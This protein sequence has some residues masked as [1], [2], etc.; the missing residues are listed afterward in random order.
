[1]WTLKGASNALKDVSSLFI[2]NFAPSS[3][4]RNPEIE[5]AVIKATNHNNSRVDY[6]SAQLL[7][8]WIRVSGHYIRPVMSALTTRMEKTR[9]WTV[10]LKGLMLLHGVFTCKVPAVQKI[11]RL[12][13]DL[14]NF[15]DRKSNMFQH[16]AF[17]RS[18]YT[19]LNK[20]SAFMMKHSDDRK[21]GT[22]R[23]G[24][25]ERPKQWTMMQHLAWLENLQGLLDMLLEI[26]PQ[27]EKMKNVLVLEAMNCIMLEIYD[28]YSRICNGIAAVLVR[29][30]SIGKTEAGMAFSI[31]QKAS[32]QA[33]VL[34][35][36]IDFCR[37]FGVTK[38]SESPKIVHIRKD[39]IQQLEQIINRASSP[40][41]AEQSIP[42][43]EDKPTMPVED[44]VVIKKP[45]T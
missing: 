26:K 18:Y 44:S 23:R 40:Q 11:G 28:I 31:L 2:A 21:E 3:A 20:K 1:M 17:I 29:L 36:Y 41:K 19:Y 25:K 42:N 22:L 33:E 30:Y 43:E 9:S 10:A 7:F 38:A 27:G 16:E 32:T 15:K 14:S 13:F 6:R 35:R 39:D 34:S 12:P 37:D 45:E 4:N 24:I 5:A 8:A